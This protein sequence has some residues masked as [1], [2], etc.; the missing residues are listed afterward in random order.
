MF[1]GRRV[2]LVVSGLI[3]I[4]ACLDMP[5]GF[6]EQPS[7]SPLVGYWAVHVENGPLG[8]G[9]QLFH[10]DSAEGVLAIAEVASRD[11]ARHWQSGLGIASSSGMAAN[12]G[13]EWALTLSDGSAS[14]MSWLLDADTLFGV[15]RV[16]G[17]TTNYSLV[18]VAVSPLIM[19]TLTTVTPPTGI[20]R[21]DVPLVLIR[22]D[23]VPIEDRQFIPHLLQRGLYGELAIPTALV[24]T[25]GHADW[26]DI[27]QWT[28]NGFGAA[29][30]S[31]HH[32][33][34]QGSTQ[35]FL[36]E[37]LGSLGDL[38]NR[39]HPTRVFVQPGTWEDSIY[40]DA[41][42]KLE[43]WRGAVFQ[44]FSSV[45]EGYARPASVS[46]PLADSMAMGLGHYTISNGAPVTN[47]LKWWLEAQRM[48]RFTVFMVHSWSLTTP[49]QLD[50]FL[51]SVSVA[52]RDGR[53][54]LAHSS[55][56]ALATER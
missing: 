56:E 19:P 12:G 23:D 41:P 34:T 4:T 30:H 44:T 47:V 1:K 28:R 32:S 21:D 35:I 16:S 2:V 5:T 46:L 40:F 10:V 15:L 39:G 31:R 43:N 13:V 42:A 55:A 6:G 48:G 25:P 50:W 24:G 29:A 9:I 20:A 11:W 36:S 49:D 53:I 14:R 51:D 54:R 7:R 38:A 27:D 37:V 33:H 22:L 3:S 45:F 52:K 17:D 26:S 18:G 8:G